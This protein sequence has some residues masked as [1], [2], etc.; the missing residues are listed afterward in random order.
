MKPIAITAA[1]VVL[2][3]VAGSAFAQ[4]IRAMPIAP[5]QNQNNLAAQVSALQSQVQQLS[6]Q[7][8]SLNT[9]LAQTA[10]S[11][12]D[13]NIKSGIDTAWINTNGDGAIKAANW[14]AANGQSVTEASSWVSANA[15][16]AGFA[17]KWVGA[18]GTA[19]MKVVTAYPTHTHSYD[20]KTQTWTNNA[21]CGGVH[22][23][24]ITGGQINTVQ[25]SPPQ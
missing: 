18:N 13:A 20:Y 19:I 10:K 24:F 1:A 14:V 22:C 3:L 6:A 2:V 4:M 21:D 23:S 9:E 7:V 16:G 11:A 17:S 15:A 8:Q 25:T 12:S 5:T